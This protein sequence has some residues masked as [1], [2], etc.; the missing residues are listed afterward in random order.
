MDSGYF[1]ATARVVLLAA[2]AALLGATGASAVPHFKVLHNFCAQ[3]G[4]SC[5]DGKLPL[6]GL[7]IDASGN[8]YGT[9]SQ[10]GHF[11][12]GAAF[13]LTNTGTGYAYKTMFHFQSVSGTN[14]QGPLLLSTGKNLYGTAHDGGTNNAGTIFTLRENRTGTRW[15]LFAVH[16]LCEEEDCADGAHPVSGLYVAGDAFDPRHGGGGYGVMADGGAFG[17]GMQ[18]QYYPKFDHVSPQQWFCT[19]SGCPY[20]DVPNGEVAFDQDNRPCLTLRE[21][22]ANNKGVLDCQ[23]DISLLRHDFCAEADC[24][25]GATPMSGVVKDDTFHVWGTT[26]SG[27]AHGQGT[28]YNVL[29]SGDHAFNVAYSFCAQLSC[30]DGQNPV[31]GLI[32]SA[33]VFY[34]TTAGGGNGGGGTIFSLDAGGAEKVLHH[35]CTR[36]GCPDGSAPQGSLVTDGAGH[37]FGIATGGGTHGGGTVFELTL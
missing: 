6:A 34:G 32:R 36:S 20:G 18:Y 7:A 13:K 25:D 21:G 14:P 31:G 24:A 2:T 35:F 16:N 26:N 28:V 12:G 15:L 3:G 19:G 30:A 11:G 27:G 23:N 37:F 5:T 33:N 17:H 10:G 29:V 4:A 22:G 8:L 1:R 9:A